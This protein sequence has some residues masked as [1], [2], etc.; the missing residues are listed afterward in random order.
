[1][2][3][4]AIS[5][6]NKGYNVSGS[7]DE[8]FEPASSNLRKAGL[9]PKNIGWDPKNI[10]PDLDA[11]ILGMHARADNPELLKAKELGISIYSFPAYVFEQV[12]DKQRVVVGGSHG[13]TSITSMIMHVLK[14]W[15][16][17]FDYL[18]GSKLE[19]FDLM[20]RLSESAPVVILEGDEYLAST[21]EPIPKFLFY[22]PHIALLTGIAWDHINVFPTFENYVEQFEQFVNSIESGGTFIYY[23]NDEMIKNIAA[24]ANHV[25]KIPY[26]QPEYEVIDNQTFLK[27]STGNIPLKIFGKHNMENLEGAKKVCEQ[28][29]LPKAKFYKAMQ[30]FKG[31][32]KRMEL[33]AQNANSALFKDFAHSPSKLKAT[34]TALK[35]QYPSRKLVACFEL[36][37]YSS[38]NGNFLREYKGCMDLADAPLVYFNDHALEIKKLPTLNPEEI[39]QS[40]DNNKL[41]IFTKTTDLLDYLNNSK[42]KNTN[43]LMMS[44]G[45]FDNLDWDVLKKLVNN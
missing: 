24:N 43:Y 36:H 31:A 9:F 40:F 25:Q 10:T 8:I 21:L 33:V 35:E 23:E 38:L 26:H 7:D 13:K 4:L 44:S 14:Y 5:L 17:D 39:Q 34:I 37:T 19:G 6:R 16:Y 2:H 11:V 27:D 45:S 42:E 15:G 29:G 1:M 30:T 12:K 22:K 20:V 41:N 32:A 18:V 3:N 28:L